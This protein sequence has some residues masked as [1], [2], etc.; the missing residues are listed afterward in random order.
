[1]RSA[2]VRVVGQA[3]RVLA[4]VATS[5]SAAAYGAGA[6]TSCAARC[7]SCSTS[8]A[9]EAIGWRASSGA[10]RAGVVPGLRSLLHTT[11]MHGSQ[12][13]TICGNQSVG[14]RMLAT[15]AA[16]T[17]IVHPLVRGGPAAERAVSIWLYSSAAWVFSM[18]VLGGVTRL[19]RS[20]L[21][22]TEWR[23]AGTRPPWTQGD[24]ENEFTKYR[25]SP[26][27]QR[28]NPSMT[29][30]EFKF[31]Y[32]MEYAHRM[33]GRALGVAFI[34][35]FSY[36]TY[37]RYLTPAL[38]TRL[39]MLFAL[40]GGQGLI[41]WWMVKSGLEAP[42]SPTDIPRVSPYR[43]AMH[44]GTA[45]AI[46]S[47]LFWTALTVSRPAPVSS[48]LS[49]LSSLL[50][51]RKRVHPL[52]A[53]IGITAMSGAFVAGND[54]GHAYNTFPLMN[55]RLV[56]ESILEL[57]PTIKNFFENT[58][59]VQ[60]DH[61]VLAL[62]TL[63]AT[64]AMWAYARRLQPALPSN[65]VNLTNLLAATA[66]AQ[67]TLGVATLLNHVPVSLGSAHQAGALTLFTV[68][69][70]LLHAL[71]KPHTAAFAAKQAVKLAHA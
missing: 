66:V 43:L 59:T 19:T 39:G 30:N 38:M 45:F 35:P 34:I 57:H 64:L 50:S 51:L 22:M 68:V 28:V 55:G 20:G 31:I 15:T 25:A 11:S 58:A 36:F 24:W 16:S 48:A 10:F 42:P 4:D 12:G 67:V 21:S 32:W 29:L 47:T 23:F 26:E 69:L 61:R 70:A 62:T 71:R 3:R 13:W 53:L 17:A 49:S 9:A 7:S 5:S 2:A 46:Y 8:A 40:G 37:K 6:S 1:M 63:G 33:W 60:F 65:V 41:G 56:P 52:A 18:V 27:F 44:L 14:A 54:A